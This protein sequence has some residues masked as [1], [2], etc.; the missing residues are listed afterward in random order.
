MTVEH[1]FTMTSGIGPDHENSREFFMSVSNPQNNTPTIVSAMASVPL[2]FEPGTHYQYGFSHDVLAAVVEVASGI[3]F[4]DYVQKNVL[5]PLGMKDTGFRMT[6]EQIGRTAACYAYNNARGAF[7]QI[8]NTN[9]FGLAANYDSGGAGL[10]SCADDYIKFI[11]T[12]ANVGCDPLLAAAMLP[13]ICGVMC[14][15]TPPLGLGMYAGMAI[16]ESDFSK[17]FKNNLW[18]VAGQYII[19]VVVLMGLLPIMGL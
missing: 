1:L 13:C 16:A 19:Q 2:Y 6:E 18:W 7:V 11:T 8:P 3:R 12:L 15:I 10:F 17:T 4:S 9:P 5:D 14:G